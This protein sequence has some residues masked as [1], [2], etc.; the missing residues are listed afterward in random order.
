M[1]SRPWPNWDHSARS[2]G[3]RRQFVSNCVS[4]D[5]VRQRL[6]YDLPYGKCGRS[7]LDC[8]IGS[9]P[10]MMI[11]GN[12]KPCFRSSRNELKAGS[13]PT[14]EQIG[15]RSNERKRCSCLYAGMIAHAAPPTHSLLEIW[16]RPRQRLSLAR[17][18]AAVWADR[19]P[20][21]F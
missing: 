9:R 13:C 1:E 16:A 2:I 19:R 7:T 15:D 10:V 4:Q 21:L 18:D 17:R 5:P 3:S 11:A 12:L 6:S 8:G 20:M 14:S